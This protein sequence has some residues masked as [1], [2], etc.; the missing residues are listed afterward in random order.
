LDPN[1]SIIEPVE[2]AGANRASSLLKNVYTL[3]GSQFWRWFGITAP[4]SLLASAVLLL[5]DQRVR[6]I[7]SS[8]P[9]SEIQYHSAEIIEAFVVRLG[10]FFISWF[11]G[12]FALA[13]VATAATGLDADDSNDVW[14]SDSYQRARQHLGPLLLVTAFTF[15]AFLAG[16]A[17]L[18]FIES[19]LIRVIGW[20]HFVRF[21]L[22]ASL[23]QLCGR[24]QYGQLV[25]NG[26]TANPFR[27]HWS[28][29]D[30]QEKRED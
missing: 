10:G 16:T 8:I 4:T 24:R 22:L 27:R 9:R 23:I 30:T 21:N 7:Y 19:S 1:Y 11:L 3:Y 17:V 14:K 6:A 13:A 5:S 2:L 20:A 28:L 12:C 26:N 25:R 18:G 29:E 15:C